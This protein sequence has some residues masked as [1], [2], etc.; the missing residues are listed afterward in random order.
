VVVVEEGVGRGSVEAG[1]EVVVASQVVEVVE[2]EVVVGTWALQEQWEAL[3]STIVSV[4]RNFGK[5]KHSNLVAQQ[6]AVAS[7][8]ICNLQ[9]SPSTLPGYGGGGGGGGGGGYGA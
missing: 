7:I 5:H 3:R 4:G 6:A 1:W 9:K 8:K 2:E